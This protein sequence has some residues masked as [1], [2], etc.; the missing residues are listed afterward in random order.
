MDS[1]FRC[2]GWPEKTGNLWPTW[3]YPIDATLPFNLSGSRNARMD[4]CYLT[5]RTVLI[6]LILAARS[7]MLKYGGRKSFVIS[8]I[9]FPCQGRHLAMG[10][11]DFPLRDAQIK[12]YGAGLIRPSLLLL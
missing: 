7:L 3:T 9:I 12:L 8:W 10:F 2:Y 1:T 6:L 5:G 4:L 11:F